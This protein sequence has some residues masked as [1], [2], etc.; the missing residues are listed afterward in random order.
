MTGGDLNATTST[1]FNL[2][3]ANQTTVNFA[4][5]AHTLNIGHT[6]G[7]TTVNNNLSVKGT[8]YVEGSVTAISSSNL[9]VAD[10]FILL[11][12]GSPSTTDGGIVIDRGSHTT[13]NIAYGFDST[14]G[15]WGYQNN[16]NDTSNALDPAAGSN[17]IS[18]SFAG[19]VF[20]EAAHGVTK[21]ITGEFAKPGTSYMDEAGNFWIYTV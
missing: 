19:Y 10:Q 7:T 17:G 6:T 16:V 15:R 4:G 5:A 1:T 9:Y 12:S 21:P 3:N 2:I 14:T 11:A 18:G 13:G 20:T 8:L